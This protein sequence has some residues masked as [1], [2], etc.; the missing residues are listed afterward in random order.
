MP[1]DL[2]GKLQYLIKWT[3]YD[4]PD[5]QDATNVNGLQ[6]IDVFHQ[7]YPDKPGPMA[8]EEADKEDW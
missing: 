3:G 2:Y 8:E 5:W 7:R 6:A 4:R 1:S